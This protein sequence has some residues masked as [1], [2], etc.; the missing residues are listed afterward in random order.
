[1]VLFVESEEGGGRAAAGEV[2]RLAVSRL[3]SSYLTDGAGQAERA[4]LPALCA[5]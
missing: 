2:D 3:T 5:D 1:M 4:G